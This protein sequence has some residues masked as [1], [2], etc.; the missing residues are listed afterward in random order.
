ME[1]QSLEQQVNELSSMTQETL[2]DFSSDLTGQSNFSPVQTG[3][4]QS[5][6]NPSQGRIPIARNKAD[7]R[8]MPDG[9]I[10]EIPD[11]QGGFMQVMNTDGVTRRVR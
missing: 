9:V 5:Q 7:A 1:V 2:R 3:A 4:S 8:T 11:G 6:Q 10:F